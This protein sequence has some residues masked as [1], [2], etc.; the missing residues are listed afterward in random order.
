MSNKTKEGVKTMLREKAAAQQG[1]YEIVL[2]EELVAEDHLLRKIDRAVDFSFIHDLC[3]DLYCP[4]NGRPAIEPELL[5]RM[6]FIGYLYGIKSE[7]KLAQ[8]VNVAP[9]TIYSLIKRDGTKTDINLLARI[10]KA[11]E[12]DLMYFS[13]EEAVSDPLT[14]EDTSKEVTPSYDFIR[15]LIARGG[16]SLTDKERL[17]LIQL[18]SEAKNL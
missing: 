6:L 15:G 8:A 3:K 12:V 5:F 18:L 9:T 17:L 4:D 14:G 10:S 11:L 16:K 1:E 13:D 2:L 7:V